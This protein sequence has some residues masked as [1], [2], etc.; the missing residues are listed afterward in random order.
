MQENSEKL[1]LPF[2]VLIQGPVSNR[3]VRSLLKTE[4]DEDEVCLKDNNQLKRRSTISIYRP[5]QITQQIVELKEPKFS[6]DEDDGFVG[7]ASEL[8]PTFAYSINNEKSVETVKRQAHDPRTQQMHY[9]LQENEMYANAP[10]LKRDVAAAQVAAADVALAEDAAAAK[11]PFLFSNLFDGS[12][13]GSNLLKAVKLEDLGAFNAIDLSAFNDQLAAIAPMDLFKNMDL[14]AMPLN[15]EM[16][17]FDDLGSAFLGAN[18]DGSQKFGF[19][20]LLGAFQG[21]NFNDFLANTGK[22]VKF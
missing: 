1:Q 2:E 5:D 22:M 12:L 20:S 9:E 19:D 17:K 4:A 14:G 6:S 11:S 15:F 16:L 7:M 18:A 13:L 21:G 3:F 10:L 8:N